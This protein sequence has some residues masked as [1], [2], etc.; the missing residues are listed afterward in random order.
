LANIGIA[1]DFLGLTE[2][3]V[4][5]LVLGLCT[6]GVSALDIYILVLLALFSLYY[7]PKMDLSN[8]LDVIQ[9]SPYLPPFD[10]HDSTALEHE[11]SPAIGLTSGLERRASEESRESNSTQLTSHSLLLIQS[12]RCPTSPP[13][14]GSLCPPLAE[15]PINSS[16]WEHSMNRV[17]ARLYNVFR[18]AG[19]SRQPRIGLWE[20]RSEEGR[21][22]IV[23]AIL[24]PFQEIESWPVLEHRVAFQLSLIW[25]ARMPHIRFWAVMTVS[26]QP[27]EPPRERP[28]SFSSASRTSL[29]SIGSA[30]TWKTDDSFSDYPVPPEFQTELNQAGVTEPR[31]IPAMDLPWKGKEAVRHHSPYERA[32]LDS[33]G[34]YALSHNRAQDSCLS[35]V[36]I[37]AIPRYQPEIRVPESAE[38]V[39]ASMIAERW[40][41]D[42]Q[43]NAET[44][45]NV[46]QTSLEEP[47]HIN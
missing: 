11:T 41:I 47:E 1:R 31:Q 22:T 16:P 37:R 36:P 8:G 23:L 25:S 27:I 28:P 40:E 33:V 45:E 32:R 43:S 34:S 5:N 15:L 9:S 12:P 17:Y 14:N 29:A 26:G 42:S 46:E 13:P 19:L 7:L 6:G 21:G 30:R 4:R 39:R 10:K 38:E 20:V 24:F 44:E 2:V 18:D 35:Y 3:F